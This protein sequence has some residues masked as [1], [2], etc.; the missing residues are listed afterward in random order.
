MSSKRDILIKKI[1]NAVGNKT[2]TE[3]SRVEFADELL[4]R[5]SSALPYAVGL[6]QREEDIL[7]LEKNINKILENY[8]KTEM[9][10][11]S[12]GPI[13]LNLHSKIQ[14]RIFRDEDKAV[15][16]YFKVVKKEVGAIGLPE[17]KPGPQITAAYYIACLIAG[18]YWNHFKKAPGY[19]NTSATPFRSVC[20]VV[21]DL[22]STFKRGQKV[23][24]ISEKVYKLAAREI[25]KKIDMNPSY[26]YMQSTHLQ[27][28]N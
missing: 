2:G 5:L 24:G 21:S 28:D 11:N 7:K 26:K 23:G 25:R 3:Q 4:I 1:A 8:K 12:L 16:H 18:L 6:E 10:L 20:S 13:A 9:I 19:S 17:K 27:G 22:L 15:I 14:R